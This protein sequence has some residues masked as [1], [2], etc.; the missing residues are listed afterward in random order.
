MVLSIMGKECWAICCGAIRAE[1]ELYATLSVLCDYRSRKMLDGIVVSTWKG[2]I[3]NVPGLRKR[4]DKLGIYAVESKSLNER[5]GDFIHLNYARQA[6]QINKGLDFIPDDVFVLKCRTDYSLDKIDLLK[7]FLQKNNTLTLGCWGNMNFGLRYRIGI[8]KMNAVTP[9]HN[10]DV[11]YVGY[12]SDVRQMVQFQ[13]KA[14]I[15][16]CQYGWIDTEIFYNL[17]SNKYPFFCELME[18]TKRIL[19]PDH[20]IIPALIAYAKRSKERFYLPKIFNRLYAFQY[21]TL[22]NCFS[23][24]FEI[25]PKQNIAPF[26]LYDV[27]AGQRNNDMGMNTPNG[28][29]CFGNVKCLRMIVQGECLPSYGYD[30]LLA[31][32]ENLKKYGYAES[33]GVSNEDVLEAAIWMKECLGINPEY[34]LNVNERKYIYRE[35]DKDG[36]EALSELCASWNIKDEYRNDFRYIMFRFANLHGYWKIY[37]YCVEV[38]GKIQ[39]ISSECYRSALVTAGRCYTPYSLYLMA[40]SLNGTEDDVRVK[41]LA[42]RYKNSRDFYWGNLPSP[43]RMTAIYLLEKYGNQ[44]D[45]FRFFEKIYSEV[46]QMYVISEQEK[47]DIFNMLSSADKIR[48]LMQTV[49]SNEYKNIKN[50][51]FVRNMASFLIDCFG[52]DAFSKEVYDSLMGYFVYR[53]YV[54]P[55]AIG[56]LSALNNLIIATESAS[57][58]YE[59]IILA[60]MLMMERMDCDAKN[61]S[62]ID[63]ALKSIRGR[64]SLNMPWLSVHCMSKEND[65]MNLQIEDLKE[66]DDYV[67]LC[68][69]LQNRNLLMKNASVLKNMFSSDSFRMCILEF[70]CLISKFEYISF[71][72]IKGQSELWFYSQRIA[73]HSSNKRFIRVKNGEGI[74]WPQGTRPSPSP[75]AAFL[76]IINGELFMSVEF[77]SVRCLYKDIF[78]MI[79]ERD[80]FDSINEEE[81]IIRLCRKTYKS[82]DYCSIADAVQ[83]ALID[84]SLIEKV[85]W[86]AMERMKMKVEEE[87]AW[88]EKIISREYA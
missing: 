76:K 57:T 15:S 60:R 50:D 43:M 26:H 61:Q 11:S 88:M 40:K 36:E 69:A 7:N 67:L 3:D 47:I 22:Y 86:D 33:I 59:V 14:F 82:D 8:E 42:G 77:A 71:L 18:K 35:I 48:K 1:Y 39:E 28:S 6:Y 66:L 29:P 65:S 51:N 34:W 12:K 24:V 10:G 45:D 21:V 2:E 52:E 27:F 37:P 68:Y 73:L 32:I 74:L 41:G 30:L 81:N 25:L 19:A 17:F 4:L 80:N 78:F 54:Y 70:F 5:I 87:D 31:E 23:I 9:F 16:E 72:M 46:S 13:M 20:K 55:F 64:I 83:Q 62:Y 38:L 49:V 75:F 53:K 85:I 58:E 56:E 84:F 44:N 79:L 63:N